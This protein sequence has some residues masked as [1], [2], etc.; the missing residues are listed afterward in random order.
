M[1][2]GSQQRPTEVTREEYADRWERTFY[3]RLNLRRPLREELPVRM[4]DIA[5]HP[6]AYSESERAYWTSEYEAEF[7]R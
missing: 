2:K 7:K 3:P 1:S 4:L 5:T 6:H